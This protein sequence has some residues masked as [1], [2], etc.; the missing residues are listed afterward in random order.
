MNTIYALMKLAWGQCE[1][2]IAKVVTVLIGALLG[3]LTYLAFVTLNYV[4]L[5]AYT[6]ST[7]ATVVFIGSTADGKISSGDLFVAST[8]SA[9]PDTIKFIVTVA[10]ALIL[11]EYAVSFFYVLYLYDN[12]SWGVVLACKRCAIWLR[13]EFDR[14]ERSYP[15]KEMVREREINDVQLRV[16]VVAI[17]NQTKCYTDKTVP[18][19]SQKESDIVD[20]TK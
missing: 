3:I 5:Q 11:I 10:I 4:R 19:A 15:T 9:I 18:E 7:G 6:L 17:R 12:K 13:Q 16:A 2:A 20:L 8:T 14:I 1:H